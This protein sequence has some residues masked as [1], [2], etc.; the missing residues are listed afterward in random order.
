MYYLFFEKEI[1][2]LF[3]L[4]IVFL[5]TSLSRQTANL[6]SS[7]IEI[8]SQESGSTWSFRGHITGNNVEW[9]RIK[10]TG[11]EMK[12]GF[13]SFLL[14]STLSRE[15]SFLSNNNDLFRWLFNLFFFLFLSNVFFTSERQWRRR[16]S[17]YRNDCVGRRLLPPIYEHPGATVYSFKPPSIDILY[18]TCAFCVCI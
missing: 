13:F 8:N 6:N 5:L 16:P 10:S 15:R 1:H 18:T 9:D 11:E 2:I 17:E 12:S 4:A 14:S 3:K 7:S